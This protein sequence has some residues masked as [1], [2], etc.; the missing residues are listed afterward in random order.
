MITE[1]CIHHMPSGTSQ[2]IDYITVLT[3]SPRPGMIPDYFPFSIVI[4]PHLR[5]AV[6]PELRVH[7]L[8]Q[9]HYLRVCTRECN[10]LAALPKV[11]ARKVRRF[12]HVVPPSILDR[13]VSDPRKRPLCHQLSP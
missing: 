1:T 6:H 12:H 11:L 10:P 5:A 8:I 3:D 9:G 13:L 2:L 7:V 4:A